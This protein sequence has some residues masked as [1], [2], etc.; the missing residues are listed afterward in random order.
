MSRHQV[1]E[2]EPAD[3]E[4]YGHSR[5][6]GRSLRILA[7]LDVLVSVRG[8][9]DGTPGMQPFYAEVRV[10][11]LTPAPSLKIDQHGKPAGPYLPGESFYVCERRELHAIAEEAFRR[12]EQAKGEE[13][14]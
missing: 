7:D 8:R 9:T 14:P 12:A 10:T 3:N 11:P 4:F 13:A 1:R 2:P 6:V 5:P